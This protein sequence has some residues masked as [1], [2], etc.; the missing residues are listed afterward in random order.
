V[1]AIREATTL[2]L[3]CRKQKRYDAPA[4]EA[5]AK[6]LKVVPEVRRHDAP[7]RP[8]R[9]AAPPAPTRVA[10]GPGSPQIYTVWNYRREAVAPAF[11]QGG[12]AA[13]QASDGEL[14]LTQVR[15]MRMRCRWPAA[16][17]C[18]KC[19][20]PAAPALPARRRLPG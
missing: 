1:D 20:A 5:S 4:L 2:V 10:A 11:E 16:P 9:S 18:A 6:L 19:S 8:A 14:A 17:A 13:Q 12:E 7:R 15:R 3:G